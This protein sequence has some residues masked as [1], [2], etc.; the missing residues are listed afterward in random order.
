MDSILIK[1]LLSHTC[2][3]GLPCNL[4]AIIE[5]PVVNGYRNKC[6]FSIGY[7]MEGKVTVGFSLGNFRYSAPSLFAEWFACK[8]L[9]V[10]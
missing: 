6:E 9:I 10:Y 5:S 4:E 7:S 8:F 1:P 2:A 3:G